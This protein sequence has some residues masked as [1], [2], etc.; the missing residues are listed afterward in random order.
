MT[1]HDLKRLELKHK[2]GS[3]Y[4]NTLD[5][6]LAALSV[7]RSDI[8]RVC[9][10][11]RKLQMRADSDYAA[12]LSCEKELVALKKGQDPTPPTLSKVKR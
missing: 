3:A 4:P 8:R 10:E 9:M 12:Y 11:Y 2:E 7:A 6:A 5:G 1:E